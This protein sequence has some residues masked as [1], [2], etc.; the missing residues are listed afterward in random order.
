M[1]GELGA[2][3]GCTRIEFATVTKGVALGHNGFR[4]RRTAMAKER[5]PMQKIREIWRLRWR[6]GYC[7]RQTAAERGR[8]H[9]RCVAHDGASASV[10]SGL[11][12]GERRQ[13]FLQTVLQK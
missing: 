5:L 2:R 11:G 3:E 13:L 7:V 4:P 10:R 8:E 1:N 6:L 9:G 12:G